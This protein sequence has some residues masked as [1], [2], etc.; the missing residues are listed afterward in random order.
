MNKKVEFPSNSYPVA[1]S[2]LDAV[3]HFDQRELSWLSGY[4]AGLAKGRDDDFQP[5][6]IGIAAENVQNTPA[7]ATTV[8]VQVLYA[9]QTGNSET[10]AQSLFSTLGQ[11]GIT[12]ELTSLN[13]FKPKELAKKDIL[14][15]AIST[16]GEGEPPDDALDFFE[17]LSSKRA[18]KLDKVQYAVLGLGD[19][20]Y[21]FF[22][23]TGKD[24]DQ[25]L[26]GLGATP[27]VARVDCDLDYDRQVEHWIESVRLKLA[28][29]KSSQD[30]ASNPGKQVGNDSFA[31][32]S[33]YSRKNPFAATVLS[34]QRITG[35]D[36][37]K[38]VHHIE[39]SI[40]DSGINY[41]PGDG[42]GIWAKNSELTVKEVLK[43]VGVNADTIVSISE[44]EIS[45][46]QALSERLELSL[47]NKNFIEEYAKKVAVFESTKSAELL[48]KVNSDYAAYIANN[49]LADVI[50]LAPITLS[51]QELVG[52]LKP[53]KPRIYSIASSPLATPEEIHLTVKLQ[54][55][56]NDA[57]TRLGTASRFLIHEL[58]EDQEVMVFIE[59][60]NRFRLP[61]SDTDIL[62]VGPG[63][64]IA[65][66]RSFLQH[67]EE[68]EAA[69][70]SWLFF[71]NAHF[72]SEFLY[73]TEFQKQLKNGVLSN[74]SVAF[75]R[76][77]QNK[78]YVQDKMLENAKEIWLWID[79]NKASFY[80][81]GDMNFMAKDVEAALLQ[82]IESQG[83]KSAEDAKN[84]LKDLK[85]NGRYQR[86]VY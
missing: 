76:D 61:E 32:Q 59:Q 63:T 34:N 48:K 38:E 23:Q 68:Q 1:P 36:S 40:E 73:Q 28:M 3:N 55:S 51:A 62:M 82:I 29:L 12:V 17:F 10:I 60:N 44:Q 19:S 8:K 20:S 81:C 26:S 21:E 72:N 53:I 16:H 7:V 13:D 45:V 31:G 69:G 22:C 39:L 24:L 71:G 6:A 49:Q 57:K 27:I 77:Q 74:L 11:A 15:F 33:S 79:S 37:D 52:L 67:R 85:R 18:P 50:A 54:T 35:R 58:D 25:A 78:V 9:S 56:E 86:D 75:S 47:I 64:G 42:V 80:V 66:F 70:D 65:P 43:L 2:V 5:Q 30:I 41:Q 14:L 84:Y 46:K 83:N 4:C